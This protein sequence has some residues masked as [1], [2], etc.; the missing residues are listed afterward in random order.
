M[1]IEVCPLNKNGFAG[2]TETGYSEP[3]NFLKEAPMADKKQ[4]PN[5]NQKTPNTQKPNPTKTPAQKPT[6]G[7]PSW[8]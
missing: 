6:T 4:A 3:N 2:I 1:S 5:S 7:K 8:K